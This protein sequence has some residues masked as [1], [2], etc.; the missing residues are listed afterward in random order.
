LQQGKQT[1]FAR[2]GSSPSPATKNESSPM[3]CFFVFGCNDAH[4]WC[5]KNEAGLRPV[6]RAFGSGRG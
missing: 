5:M 6:K 2:F 1:K 3:D 4:R